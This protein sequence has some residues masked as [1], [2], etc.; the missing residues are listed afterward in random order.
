[1][2]A[3]ANHDAVPPAQPSYLER[4]Q[5][6]MSEHAELFATLDLGGWTPRLMRMPVVA[7]RRSSVHRK[8]SRQLALPLQPHL[9][10]SKAP[11]IGS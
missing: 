1:M 4:A 6:L 9:I 3:L 2:S 5:W 8:R 7:P 10:V 11:R